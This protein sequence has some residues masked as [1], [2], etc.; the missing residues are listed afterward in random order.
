MDVGQKVEVVIGEAVPVD[1]AGEVLGSVT[2][3]VLINVAKEMLVDVA[4]VPEESVMQ[5]SRPPGILTAKVW[6]SP[7]QQL[8][9]ALSW[10]QQ[11]LSYPQGVRIALVDRNKSG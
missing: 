7:S 4:G 8:R 10:P 11:K 1:A 6:L 9:A 3:V 2:G 5:A